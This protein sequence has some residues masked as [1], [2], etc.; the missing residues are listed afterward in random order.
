MK[1]KYNNFIRNPTIRETKSHL[2]PWIRLKLQLLYLSHGASGKIRRIRANTRVWILQIDLLCTFPSPH[3]P[4]YWKTMENTSWNNHRTTRTTRQNETSHPSPNLCRMV[5]S[6]LELLFQLCNTSW[7][8]R[9]LLCSMP[10][11]MRIDFH[12]CTSLRMWS[13]LKSPDIS[14]N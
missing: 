5:A 7:S 1:T 10:E 8:C 4:D 9:Q 14:C 11:L 3:G 6:V 12:P 2:Q 13:G